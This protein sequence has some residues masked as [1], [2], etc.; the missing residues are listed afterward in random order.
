MFGIFQKGDAVYNVLYMPYHFTMDL[1]S[2]WIVLIM[3]YNYG[4]ALGSKSPIMTSVQTAVCFAL[5]ACTWG[6]NEAGASVIDV[7]Y[8]SSQGMF[9]SFFVCWFVCQVEKFC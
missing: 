1:L 5:I 7:T 8:F 9:V 6:T 4:K 2:L 3:A